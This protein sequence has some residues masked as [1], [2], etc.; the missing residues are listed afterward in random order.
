MT[1]DVKKA[2]EEALEE[3]TNERQK[4]AKQKFKDKIIALRKAELVVANIKREIEDLELEL[5]NA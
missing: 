1:V 4:E 5:R 3:V 2:R